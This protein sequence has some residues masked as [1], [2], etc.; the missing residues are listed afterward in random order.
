MKNTFTAQTSPWGKEHTPTQ[1]IQCLCKPF[2]VKP[3]KSDHIGDGDFWS[4][5]RGWSLLE[6]KNALAL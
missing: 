3:L 6:V 4:L 2:A 5:W 1:N